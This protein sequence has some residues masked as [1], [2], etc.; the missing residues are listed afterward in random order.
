MVSTNTD[1]EIDDLGGTWIFV[2]TRTSSLIPGV[3]HDSDYL[4]F[5]WWLRGVTDS[6][7]DTEYSVG[8]FYDGADLMTFHAISGKI[9]LRDRGIQRPGG[10][11]VCAE[12]V[13]PEWRCRR[14]EGR[15][16]H[17]GRHPDGEFR[18]G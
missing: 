12:D 17:G 2:P 18:R 1:G 5:G 7:G 4:A 10:R 3:D 11:Q 6:D 13:D 15:P 14:P 9:S 8:T 16:F